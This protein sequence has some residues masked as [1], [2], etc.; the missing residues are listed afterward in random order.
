[1]VFV[2]GVTAGWSADVRASRRPRGECLTREA[3]PLVCRLPCP[4]FHSVDREWKVKDENNMSLCHWFLLV[5]VPS[6]LGISAVMVPILCG[7]PHVSPTAKPLTADELTKVG[8]LAS[9]LREEQIR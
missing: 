8:V 4:R 6:R 1:M 9:I 5:V 2:P 3:G 7:R